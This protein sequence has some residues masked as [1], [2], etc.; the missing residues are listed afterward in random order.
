MIDFL[1]FL[2]IWSDLLL[3]SQPGNCDFLFLFLLISECV[4]APNKKKWIG[5]L[6]IQNPTNGCIYSLLYNPKEYL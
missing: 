6:F 1:F 5:S 2:D 4:V 3:S